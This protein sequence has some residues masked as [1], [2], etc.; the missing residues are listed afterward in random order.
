ME[1]RWGRRQVADI[2][3]QCASHPDLRGTGR[4]LNLSLTGAYLQT[5]LPL[6][7]SAL[8]R[9]RLATPMC[10]AGN[11]RFIAASVVRR[12]A[13][14]VGLEWCGTLNETFHY[15]GV[16]LHVNT[17]ATHVNTS[18]TSHSAAVRLLDEYSRDYKHLAT[19]V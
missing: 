9:L 16:S 18:V 5:A 15:L 11:T 13:L 8:V 3:V 4:I 19:A 10:A 2:A 12:D 1:H 14:G 7:L 17:L 6:R